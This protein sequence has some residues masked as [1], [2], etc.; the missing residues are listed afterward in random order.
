MIRWQSGAASPLRCWASSDEAPRVP[1]RKHTLSRR[2][3]SVCL[4]VLGRTASGWCR[5]S[6]MLRLL[7][8]SAIGSGSSMVVRLSRLKLARGPSVVTTARRCASSTP[9][10]TK[11]CTV[12]RSRYSR[13][14]ARQRQD[15]AAFRADG[16]GIIVLDGPAAGKRFGQIAEATEDES[17]CDPVSHSDPV[18]IARLRGHGILDGTRDMIFAN[19]PSD[20]NVA[21]SVHASLTALGCDGLRQAMPRH[22]D[23][24]DHAGGRCARCA[25][26]PQE[27]QEPAARAPDRG[28]DRAGPERGWVTRA[29][30]P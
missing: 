3:S 7:R 18:S 5:I 21:I 22:G 13:G 24:G 8:V 15:Q 20:R 16:P 9:G 26:N 2:L 29:R 4:K 23:P 25:L 28:A 11:G 19:Y 17:G 6:S 10:L 30:G 27:S 14:V 12:R 1:D